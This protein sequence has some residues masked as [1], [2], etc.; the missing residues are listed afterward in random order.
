MTRKN[1][2]KSN[3]QTRTSPPSLPTAKGADGAFRRWAT[4]GLCLL[5]AGGGA[6]AFMEFV[7]WNK[8]PGKLVG[9]W[10][11]VQGP[12]EYKEAVFEFHRSGKM[13]GRLND[14]E[15]LRI[16]NAVVSVEGDNLHIKTRR[17]RSGEEHVSVQT[18]RTLSETELVLADER[19]RVMKMARIP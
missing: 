12:P 11:V 19:G 15:K 3:K 5:C 9:S 7:V 10:E 4:L 2:H 8:L 1:S 14:N 6:W 17:P 13:V 18:I 16:M